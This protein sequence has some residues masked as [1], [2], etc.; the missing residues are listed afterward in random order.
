MKEMSSCEGCEAIASGIV[1]R[2][3]LRDSPN[4]HCNYSVQIRLQERIERPQIQ[5]RR[6][7]SLEQNRRSLHRKAVVSLPEATLVDEFRFPGKVLHENQDPTQRNR[8]I[9][10]EVK[11]ATVAATI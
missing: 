4:Q 8:R 6:F 10:H 9:Q 1:F 5:V 7:G 11:N 2:K 3:I